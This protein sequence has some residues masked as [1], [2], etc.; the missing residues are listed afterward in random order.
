MNI[1]A[2]R[3][4]IQTTHRVHGII[5]GKD[6]AA[7]VIP[8]SCELIYNLRAPT[9]EELEALIPRVINCFE[10]AGTATGCKVDVKKF[11][12]YKNV[13]NNPALAASYQS[14]MEDHYEDQI[15]DETF[16]ASTGK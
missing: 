15:G 9:V 8:A 5:Q 6:W 4:Q 2:L 11:P 13:V 12:L 14:F 3:Q 7:N 1:S 16:F 10:A